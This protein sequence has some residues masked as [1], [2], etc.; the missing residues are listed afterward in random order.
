MSY[1]SWQTARARSHRSARRLEKESRSLPRSANFGSA[2]LIIFKL[3]GAAVPKKRTS[4]GEGPGQPVLKIALGEVGDGSSIA[5]LL[6]RRA[7]AKKDASSA[8]RF[9]ARFEE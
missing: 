7:V 6:E 1:G 9:R 5:T 4:L 8:G 3:C 2:A